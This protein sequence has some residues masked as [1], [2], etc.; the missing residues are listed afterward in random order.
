MM[1]NRLK[2]KLAGIGVAA[3]VFAM[4]SPQPLPAQA[5]ELRIFTF[6]GSYND[7]LKKVVVDPFEKATGIKVTL[8]S[9]SMKIGQIRTM[10]ESGAVTADLI[11]GDPWDAAA[12]CDEGI[13]DKIDPSFLGDLS[14]MRPGSVIPC[15]IG[16]HMFTVTFTWD[17]DKTPNAPKD[18]AGFF[19]IKKYPGKRSLTSRLYTTFEY[20]LLADG[21]PPDQI[22]NVLRQPDGIER[23]FKVLDPMKDQIVWWDA[24]QISVTTLAN[25]E[26]AYS[27][28]PINRYFNAVLNDKRNWET[29]WDHFAY[30]YDTWFI[31]KGA[32][33]KE[34]A[35][36]FL[37][38]MMDPK[39]LG[40]LATLFVTPPARISALQYMDP[41][42]SK[43]IDFN[44]GPIPMDVSFWADHLDSFNKKFEAWQQK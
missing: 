30:G 21:V 16:S 37:Q 44:K 29:T 1:R 4:A 28:V 42:V 11:V 2:I 10:V 36:K 41:Q 9:W 22:Y 31:P 7:F 43:R 15:G 8:D 35:I 5:E 38:Y 6:G 18:M 23:V 20:A 14:D 17:K 25:N 32:P 34:N 19:D 26:V 13:L 3:A 24:A 12:G 33:N 39:R 40:E 27:L